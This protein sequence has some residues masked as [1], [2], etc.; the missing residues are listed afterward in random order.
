MSIPP[1]PKGASLAGLKVLVVDDDA[2]NLFALKSALEER[3]IRV[4]HAGNGKVALNLLQEHDDVDLVLMDTDD[5]GDRRPVGDEG[6]PG[7][8]SAIARCQSSRSPRRP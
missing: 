3:G 8:R 5:A 1:L 7:E 2:R 4:L 6:N